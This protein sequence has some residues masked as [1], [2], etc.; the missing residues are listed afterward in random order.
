MTFPWVVYC[1]FRDLFAGKLRKTDW[2]AKSFSSVWTMVLAGA[3]IKK[4]AVER[5]RMFRNKFLHFC[6]SLLADMILKNLLQCPAETQCHLFILKKTTS[7]D[8]CFRLLLALLRCYLLIYRF[9]L[10]Y[11]C[12][13]VS[14]PNLDTPKI[15][16]T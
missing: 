16:W 2:L 12:V 9:N 14:R 8:G 15:T 13:C 4:T 10:V 5:K 3:K 7:M 11:M 1:F 6:I